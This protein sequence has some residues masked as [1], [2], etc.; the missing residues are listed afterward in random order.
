M[1]EKSEELHA[2]LKQINISNIITINRLIETSLKL[3]VKTK[4]ITSNSLNSKYRLRLLNALYKM[5]K[6]NKRN[7]NKYMDMDKNKFLLNFI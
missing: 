5:D 3:E 6:Q 1:K 7:E 4:K 2:K